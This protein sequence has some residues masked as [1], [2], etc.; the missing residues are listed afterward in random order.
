LLIWELSLFGEFAG[1]LVPVTVV[2]FAVFSLESSWACELVWLS[3]FVATA[4]EFGLSTFF[5]VQSST[6]APSAFDV[7]LLGCDT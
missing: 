2:A 7:V 3:L 5:V 1:E 4:F 6:L